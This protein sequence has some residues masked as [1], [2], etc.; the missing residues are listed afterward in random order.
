MSGRAP[1]PPP[2]MHERALWDVRAIM[3]YTR[4]GQTIVQEKFLADPDFPKPIHPTGPDGH[5]RWFAGDVWRYF[6]SKGKQAA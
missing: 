1:A 2:I 3:D 4:F 5:P 6:E